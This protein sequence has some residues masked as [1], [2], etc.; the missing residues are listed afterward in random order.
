MFLRI[1]LYD[2]NPKVSMEEYLNFE[3]RVSEKYT[4]IA[5]ARGAL[6]T[7][8]YRPQYILPGPHLTMAG[9][10]PFQLAGVYFAEGTLEGFRSSPRP[11]P[12]PEFVELLQEANT[13]AHPASD[14]QHV[15]D[16]SPIEW[17]V[18]REWDL[19]GKFLRIHIYA[20]ESNIANNTTNGV[21]HVG[22]FEW[23][24][25]SLFCAVDLIDSEIATSK[26]FIA[27]SKY[28]KNAEV[29]LLQPLVPAR[30]TITLLEKIGV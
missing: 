23:T 22:I 15:L 13:Y 28:E 27:L 19:V 1:D 8:L 7:G 5:E 16:L 10:Q 9:A 6:Y 20:S 29:I 24:D 4:K 30:G 3:R 2:I 25:T 26:K 14:H 21:S 18:A 12:T 17:S 11:A